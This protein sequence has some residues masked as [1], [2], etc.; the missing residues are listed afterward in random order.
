MLPLPGAVL[1]PNQGTKIPH[2][3]LWSKK[4]K[5]S[6]GIIQILHL[7]PLVCLFTFFHRNIDLGDYWMSPPDISG[8]II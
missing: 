8:S 2:A 7:L 1:I 4:E 5:E 3:L 6:S